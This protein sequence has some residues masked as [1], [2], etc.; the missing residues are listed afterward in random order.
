MYTEILEALGLSPNE[1]KI[2]ESLVE[3]GESTISQVAV[4]AKI[5]R[6]NAY[7]AIERLIEKGLCFQIFSHTENRYNA[8]DPDKL[9]ELYAEREQRLR[10]IIP[11]LKM[12]FV[13][14]FA[15]REAYIYRG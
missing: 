15:P 8:V 12:K 13:E 11:D 2:Y 3:R 4:A 7:D 1:A 10:E 6:R 5:H 9:V 14:R